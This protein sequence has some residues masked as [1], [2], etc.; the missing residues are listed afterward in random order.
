MATEFNNEFGYGNVKNSSFPLE[1]DIYQGFV[2]RK[3]NIILNFTGN[4]PGEIKDKKDCVLLAGSDGKTKI[5]VYVLKIQE[6]SSGSSIYLVLTGGDETKTK[7]EIYKHFLEGKYL[8]GNFNWFSDPSLI[9]NIKSYNDI[10][11]N[12][13]DA[14]Y[15]EIK[16]HYTQPRTYTD[17]NGDKINQA[18]RTITWDLFD[19]FVNKD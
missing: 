18:W 6:C 12:D 1:R 3:N 9:F 10:N 14:D 13:K 7:E 15:S 4:P 16:L 19:E 11:V 5:S 17:E 8:I 2:T